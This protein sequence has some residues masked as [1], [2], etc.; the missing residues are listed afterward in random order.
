[1]PE[2]LVQVVTTANG[3]ATLSWV[4]AGESAT[5]EDAVARAANAALLGGD[6]H[7][8]EVALPTTDSVGRRAVLRAG[9]RLE[10]LRRDAERLPD[11]SFGD[12]AVFARLARDQVHGPDGF[13]GVMNSALPKKRLIAH[14]LLQDGAG[15]LLL[16]ETQFKSDWEL[17]GGIV[18]PDESP[19]LGALREVREELGVD[20][21]VGRLLLVD[22]MP[23]YLGWGDALELI[24][25]GPTV[26][27]ADLT[28]FVLQPTEIRS[29]R[30]L[31]L[32]QARSVVTPLSH[33]RLTVAMGLEAGEVAYLENGRRTG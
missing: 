33:R 10:G 7:R 19:R 30:L 25:A 14:V 24:F 13:S 29:V 32:D 5:L 26:T 8:L 31:T 12:V 23:P 17:P 20:L 27:A 28:G 16:C 22:W 9:F 1:M 4:G 21:P 15:R 2:V 3:V 18:E 11:G 6:V